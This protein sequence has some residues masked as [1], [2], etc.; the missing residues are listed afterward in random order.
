M[1]NDRNKTSTRQG[2][3][4]HKRLL[5]GL[6]SRWL[7]NVC[8]ASMIT[9]E[10]SVWD[11]DVIQAKSRVVWQ[12]L[13]TFSPPSHNR[14]I[15]IWKMKWSSPIP[16]HRS[17]LYP[18]SSCSIRR[19]FLSMTLT[20][21][22]G[23]HGGDISPSPSSFRI[24]DDWTDLI[25]LGIVFV[26][27]PGLFYSPRIH[28]KTHCLLTGCIDCFTVWGLCFYLRRLK[29]WFPGCK[30]RYPLDNGV[31]PTLLCSTDQ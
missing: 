31:P 22:H 14:S 30:I 13:P 25:S 18:N 10:N 7:M 29:F 2:I 4:R 15:C 6:G 27:Y 17:E 8:K 19:H 16:R 12:K 11:T 3:I 23:W 21:R 28:P 20:K 26:L 24:P 1:R 9:W 5:L